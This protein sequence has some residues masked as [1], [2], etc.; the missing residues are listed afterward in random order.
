VALQ[1]VEGA[2]EQVV[3]DPFVEAGHHNSEVVTVSKKV[4][5][6]K[7]RHGSNKEQRIE[8]KITK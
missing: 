5:F 8:E 4:S 6:Q 1:G 7:I 3:G 2:V